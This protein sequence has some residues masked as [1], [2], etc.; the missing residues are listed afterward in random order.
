MYVFLLLVFL[1]AVCFYIF[2]I[3]IMPLNLTNAKPEASIMAACN[4][5]ERSLF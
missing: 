4:A 3:L 2:F 5:E 1:N